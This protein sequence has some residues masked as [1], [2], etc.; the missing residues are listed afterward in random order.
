M[1]DIIKLDRRTKIFVILYILFV[2]AVVIFP[3]KYI[4][5][6]ATPRQIMTVVM[7][8]TSYTYSRC[9]FWDEYIKYYL[10]FIAV[11]GISSMLTGYTNEFLIKFLSFY[12]VCYTAYW[13]TKILNES[14]GSTFILLFTLTAIGF[15]DAGVT[16]LQAMGNPLATTITDILGVTSNNYNYIKALEH[17]TDEILI[18]SMPGLVSNPINN[19]YLLMSSA[20]SSTFLF[21]YSKK[22]FALCCMLFI[23]LGSFMCQ[24]RSSFYSALLCCLLMIVLLL[25]N[26]K[27][28]LQPIFLIL[29]VCIIGYGLSYLYD[30]LM[31]S[32]TRYALGIKDNGRLR[33]YNETIAYLK[34]N[35]L[36]GGYYES[37]AVPHNMLIQAFLSGGIVGLIPLIILTVK[38]MLVFF[39]NITEFFDSDFISAVCSVTFF[40]IFLS[41]MF[42]TV[43]IVSGEVLIWLVWGGVNDVEDK[44]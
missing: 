38:Q 24:Q 10:A 8:I 31:T 26:S 36:L 37:H 41:S 13:S 20:V 28:T 5:G 12:L 21:R 18:T 11:F 19:G 32:P 2:V 7:L 15:A 34:Y 22:Y 14:V 39:R 30:Y 23:L 1:T 27:S 29:G 3:S 16:I 9:L 4:A 42:H 40:A 17:S 33:L 43:S 6:I 44:L 35:W 25:Q